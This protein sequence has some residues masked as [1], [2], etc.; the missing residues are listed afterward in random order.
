MVRFGNRVTSGH[1]RRAFHL[2]FWTRLIQLSFSIAPNDK[3]SKKCFL[4]SRWNFR[5]N[6]LSLRSD[7]DQFFFFK[8]L[9]FNY[10]LFFNYFLDLRFLHFSENLENQEDENEGQELQ[11]SSRTPEYDILSSIRLA[12]VR[13]KMARE[14][15]MVAGFTRNFMNGF[16]F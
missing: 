8:Y 15:G 13:E 7:S 9:Y 12:N 10:K 11:R 6:D 5:K 16:D 3:F 2:G 4:K 14:R 1:C